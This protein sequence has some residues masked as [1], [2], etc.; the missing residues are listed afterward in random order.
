MT[1]LSRLESGQR[2]PNFELLPLD[3]AHG[4]PLDELIGAPPT[5][6]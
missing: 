4:V 5:G 3:K 2:R 6:E 1:M